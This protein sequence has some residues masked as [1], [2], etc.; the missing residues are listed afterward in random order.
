MTLLD[1]LNPMQRKAAEI[2]EGPLLILAGAG[3]GKTRTVIY[4]IAHL[5]GDCGVEPYQIL[6]LTFTNKAAG[7]MRSRIQSFDIPGAEQ[8]WMGTFHSICARMLRIHGEALGFTSS[9]TIYDSSDAKAL[10]K[11]CMEALGITDKALNADSVAGMI[12]TA[13]N[14]AISP[15]E[16]LKEYGNRYRAKDIYSVYAL[17]TKK[18]L[19]NNAMDFDDLLFNTYRLFGQQPEVLEHYQNR[20]LHVLVDEYQDTNRLQY[21]IVAMIAKKHKNLCVCG[22]DDQSIY[23]WRGADI[24]NILEFEEDFPNANVVRLEQNYR[25]TA[26]ILNAANKLIKHNKGRKGKNLWTLS[27]D[28]EKIHILENMRDIEEGERVVRE[29]N[30]K[31]E[32]EGFRYSDFAV[33][34]RTNAQSRVIEECLIRGA[35]PYQIVRGTRFYERMEVKDIM[36]YLRLAVNGFDSV[37]FE[38]AVTTPKRGIGPACIDKLAAFAE[39][40]GLSIVDA[41]KR[42]D[43]AGNISASLCGRLRS[44]AGIIDSV[45]EAAAQDGLERAVKTAIEKSGYADYIRVSQ[46]DNYESRLE[47]LDELINAAADFAQTSEDPS[48]NAFLENAALIAGVD[49]LEDEDGNVLLMSIHNSKGLEFKCVFVVG[50]EEGLFPLPKACEDDD[51]L[52]E[53]RRLCYVAMT[54][55]MQCLYMSYSRQRRQYG[56]TKSARPSRFLGEIPAEL[57]DARSGIVKDMNEFERIQTYNKVQAQFVKTS[58]PGTQERKQNEAI[59]ENYSVADKIEHPAWG[60]GTVIDVAGSGKDSVLTVAFAGLGVKKIVPGYVQIKKV[61]E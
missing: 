7:E 40:K 51:E 59:I 24:R 61:K 57:T 53:E 10:I 49:N 27:G 36:S 41:A 58:A 17:Y 4:R 19:E 43:E 48:L 37:S 13:K 50:V 20:F 30:K 9:F 25:S 34:Y 12:S 44:F 6:A 3:S 42:S 56:M 38:R 28:G 31:V 16:F 52:E 5:L 22:D 26:N 55:A 46:P 35:V 18:L 39:F 1:E 32:G 8:I 29:I 45:N 54:R 60:V 11:Q 14:N 47:N 15:E 2:I 21:E 23:G 33:L